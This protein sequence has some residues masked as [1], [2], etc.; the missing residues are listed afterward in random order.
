MIEKLALA[1]VHA[2][3]R[4]RRYFQAFNIEVQTDLQ[5]QQILRKPEVSGRLTK[6]AIKLSAF[7]TTYRTRGPVKGQAVAD[8]LT[9]VP[10]GESTKEKS[11]LPKVWNLYT[12]G[13]S[14]KEGSGVGLILID[15]DGK[16][17][18][19]A[20]RFEFKTSNNEAEYQ[21]LLA[22]LQTAGKA[23]ATSVLA[24]VD[25]LLVANQVSGEYEARE[26]N[27]IQYLKQVNNLISSFDSC[28]IVHIP[29]SKNKKA[30]ALSKLASV[31]FCH[32]S[33]EV[34]VET[35]QAPA[36]HQTES[37]MSISVQ[38]K[39]WMTPILD[40]LRDGTLPEEK[41]QARKLKVKALQYQV[42]GGKLY[43]KTFLGPLLKCLTPEEASYVIREIHWG[44]CDIHSGPRMVVAKAMN[45]GYFWPGMHQSA[46]SELQACEYCQRH[47]PISH[48]AKNNLIPVTSAW[49]FQKWG[50][51]IVG[52][53]PVSTGG[54]RFLLVAIDY[55]TKWIE[56]KPSELSP[57]IKY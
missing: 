42:H 53:F 16:E 19:Y 40:Y 49:P 41:G 26:A 47:A 48:R 14:S 21:A 11:T 36:I 4:L 38:E 15:P 33:K 30:D 9:E 45:A 25:S 34:L 27:M 28:K 13:A 20:L 17:Y 35:L 56:A 5:I 57:G 12:D 22:G 37:V 44:I 32:L 39:S 18:T 10:T 50:I 52:P 24:H 46:V 3:R 8:F 51:D 55:F 43:R 54:V 7:D 2:S 31:A 6:W 29:R 1:L 23:G